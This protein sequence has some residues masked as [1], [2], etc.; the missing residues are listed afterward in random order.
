MLQASIPTILNQAKTNFVYFSEKAE[1]FI[2]SLSS[3]VPT[4]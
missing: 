2:N 1:Q 3:H 4:K